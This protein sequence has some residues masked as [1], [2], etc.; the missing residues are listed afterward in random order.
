MFDHILVP[1]GAEAAAVR[2]GL[3]RGLKQSPKPDQASPGVLAIAMGPEATAQR[4]TTALD[5][6][7]L[8]PGS[9]VL[10][11]G[12]AGSLSPQLG[13]GNVVIYDRFVPLVSPLVSTSASALASTS[14]VQPIPL[15]KR[16]TLQLCSAELKSRLP[17]AQV[18]TALS[19]DHLIHSA[20]EK[21]QLQASTGAQAVDMEAAAIQT[22][23]SPKGIQI[24]T[25]RVISD[26]L[27][28][29]LPNIEPAIN[30]HGELDGVKMAI[31]M[32]S[33]PKAS[34][35]LIRGSL[36]ALKVLETVTYRIFSKP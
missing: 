2:R 7:D 19:S 9:R 1:Q 3:K 32:F 20:Q 21:A 11:L 22:R 25:V 30:E 35:N 33:Q 17:E 13:L 5:R 36:Q 8:A 6:G 16:E 26:D 10:V 15:N 28:M 14:A 23:L 4:L 34:I 12:V 18:I 31:A 29:D 24:S 27:G